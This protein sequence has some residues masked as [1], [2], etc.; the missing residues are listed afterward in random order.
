MKIVT[1]ACP[2]CGTFVAGNVLEKERV[3]KCPREGCTNI[4][5]FDDLNETDR[6]YILR[7]VEKYSVE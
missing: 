6:Q 4:L 3:L 7:N 2:D 5:Q 1:L